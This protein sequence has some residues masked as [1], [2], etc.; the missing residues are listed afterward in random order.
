M[1]EVK[2]LAVIDGKTLLSLDVEPPK[3]IIDRFLPT[4]LHM[5]AGSPKIDKSRLALWL[6]QQV[7]KAKLCGTLKHGRAARC[8]SL[9]RTR[10]S[11]C[12][13]GCPASRRTA[14]DRANSPPAPTACP[15]P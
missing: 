10:L 11:V 7:Q 5:L 3:F 9:W 13:S 12:I 2:S 14:R 15:V 6:C 8:T 1:S 4:G